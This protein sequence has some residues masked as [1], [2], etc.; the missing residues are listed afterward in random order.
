MDLAEEVRQEAKMRRELFL[1]PWQARSMFQDFG[2][3]TAIQ[4]LELLFT[5]AGA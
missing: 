2:D 4:V 1:S 5:R 3:R